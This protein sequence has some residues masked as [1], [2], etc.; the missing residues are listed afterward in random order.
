MKTSFN[1]VWLFSLS[2]G[3]ISSVACLRQIWST[4]SAQAS[5]TGQFKCYRKRYILACIYLK[6]E[7]NHTNNSLI[8]LG[9]VNYM[10]YMMSLDLVKN[11]TLG[12][13]Y[14]EILFS[15]F[16]QCCSWSPSMLFHRSKTMQFTLLIAASSCL[17]CM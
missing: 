4:L 2:A 14:H 10:D 16:L 9:K 12:I 3:I 6:Y 17:L 15:N 7:P 5:R 13:I 11:Q 1:L 8:S